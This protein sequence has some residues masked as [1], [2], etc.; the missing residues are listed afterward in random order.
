MMDSMA[1]INLNNDQ[2]NQRKIH[3]PQ[4]LAG[5]NLVSFETR[6]CLKDDISQRR[7][8]I[9]EISFRGELKN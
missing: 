7:M 8:K 2:T 4:L 3:S 5:E 9:K 6:N 1:L